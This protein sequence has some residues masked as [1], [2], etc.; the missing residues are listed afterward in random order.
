MLS[1]ACSET[2]KAPTPT[3]AA[4]PAA[5]PSKSDNPSD[6]A[7]GDELCVCV[8]D[9]RPVRVLLPLGVQDW[10]RVADSLGVLDSLDE[11]LG[12]LVPVALRVCAPLPLGVCVLVNCGLCDVLCEWLWVMVGVT[13]TEGLS[14][15]ESDCVRLGVTVAEA[16]TVVLWVRLC[17]CEGV[18]A[19]D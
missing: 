1:R 18:D 4:L 11:L 19:A 16:V 6:V 5:V 14:V 9:G 13:V 12:L 15:E 10:L 7:L 2:E 17:V 8:G 3:M